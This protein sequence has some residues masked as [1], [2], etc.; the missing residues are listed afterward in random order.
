MLV[1]PEDFRGAEGM[2]K[3][4]IYCQDAR[5]VFFQILEKFFNWG[6]KAVISSDTII[7][8]SRI[9][10]RVSIGNHSYIGEDVCE[11]TSIILPIYPFMPR[12][13]QDEVIH[14]IKKVVYDC[15]N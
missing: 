8:T 4:V 12:G 10:K 1:A 14:V 13:E 15:K 2:P 9:G 11:D 3:N 7:W 6:K 5:T